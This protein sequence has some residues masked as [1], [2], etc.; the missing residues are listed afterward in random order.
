MALGDEGL[1]RTIIPHPGEST[2]ARYPQGSSTRTQKREEL[3]AA[4]HTEKIPE[5]HGVTDAF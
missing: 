2:S 5:Q 1:R 3:I 4:I